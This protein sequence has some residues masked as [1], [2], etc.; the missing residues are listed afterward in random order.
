MSQAPPI[1]AARMRGR[2]D[3]RAAA[4]G[5]RRRAVIAVALLVTV[6]GASAC[7]KA[8][9]V[10]A[11]RPASEAP[12]TLSDP[13]ESRAAADVRGST[14]GTDVVG[15]ATT[16]SPRATTSS[17]PAT[18]SAGSAPTT[19]PGVATTAREPVATTSNAAAGSTTAFCNRNAQ[20]TRDF[21]DLDPTSDFGNYLAMLRRVTAELAVLAPPAIKADVQTVADAF[22]SIKTA[23]Q[24]NE[25]TNDATVK[26]ASD[27]VTAWAEKNCPQP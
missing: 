12:V 17:A 9:D 25:M 1:R 10:V 21:D 13:P 23:D 5:P 14:T 20:A 6:V 27:R 24:I 22:A 8:D 18:T 19:A 11:S 15:T 7:A 16:T 26:A 2:A 4:A 3:R